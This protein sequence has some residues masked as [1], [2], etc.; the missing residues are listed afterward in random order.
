MQKDIEEVETK[1]EQEW[2]LQTWEN[3]TIPEGQDPIAKAT[4]LLEKSKL[5]DANQKSKD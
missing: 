2:C 1:K 3:N 4:A 5:I